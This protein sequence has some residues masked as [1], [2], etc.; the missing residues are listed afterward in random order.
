MY[1][2]QGQRTLAGCN[3]A[4]G[5]LSHSGHRLCDERANAAR[6]GLGSRNPAKPDL[7]IRPSFETSRG[8]GA[9][10]RINRLR[11]F[12]AAA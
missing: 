3:V 12:A 2:I 7:R 5:D 6:F 8:G 10:G 4:A 1:L 11:R 9:A